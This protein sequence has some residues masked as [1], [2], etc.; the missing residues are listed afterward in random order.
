MVKQHRQ[1]YLSARCPRR[2]SVGAAEANAKAALA[3]ESAKARDTLRAAEG[4]AA[5]R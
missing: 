2:R 1:T 5:R 3:G 4:E